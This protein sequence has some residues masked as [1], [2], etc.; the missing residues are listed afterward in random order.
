[1]GVT[2]GWD[3]PLAVLTSGFLAVTGGWDF[4]LP[5]LTCGFIW[6]W[7]NDQV[8]AETDSGLAERAALAVFLLVVDQAPVPQLRAMVSR[9]Q[10]ADRPSS[11]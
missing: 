2:G 10:F 4:L 6:W 9:T 1:M 7:R 8:A 5:V 11:A 3:F